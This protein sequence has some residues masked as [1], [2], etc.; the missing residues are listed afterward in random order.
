MKSDGTYS[1]VLT[2]H[3]GEVSEGSRHQQS[4]EPQRP[5][6]HRR[7]EAVPCSDQAPGYPL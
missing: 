7:V 2:D 5:Q 3:V 1:L 6:T 4:G